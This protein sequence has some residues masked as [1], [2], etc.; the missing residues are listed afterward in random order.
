MGTRGG[1]IKSPGNPVLGGG[2]GTCFDP[3]VISDGG[4]YRMYFGWRPQNAIGLVESADGVHWSMPRI[5]LCSIPRKEHTEEHVNRQCVLKKGDAYHMWYSGQGQDRT[6]RHAWIFHATSI[7]GYE[8]RR[9]GYGPVL[10]GDSPWES[11]GVMCPHVMWDEERSLYRMWYSGMRDGGRMYE[12]DAIG[13]AESE[14]GT[15]WRKHPGNP[16]FTADAESPC[17]SLKVTACQVLRHGAWHYMFYIG[18]QTHERATI[19]LAKSRDGISN[20]QRHPMNPI[21]APDE[22]AWDSDACYKPFSL[23][24]NGRWLLWYNGRSAHLEQIGLAV[25]EGEDLGFV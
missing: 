7:D 17:D 12:P 22:G 21:I 11:L 24:E 14:D 2:H 20:W 10:G 6:M 13:Y 19:C 18:F 9:E 3:T 5:V 8:W 15:S 4:V 25:K 23:F 16:V 1:W